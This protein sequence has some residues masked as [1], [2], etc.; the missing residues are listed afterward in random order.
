M[1]YTDIDTEDLARTRNAIGGLK[2]IMDSLSYTGSGIPTEAHVML[3]K[4]ES[5]AEF[6][7]RRA[8]VLKAKRGL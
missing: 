6:L 8:A 5:Q 4:L 3:E 7:E 2:A 1:P